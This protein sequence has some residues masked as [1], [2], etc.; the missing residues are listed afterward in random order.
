MHYGGHGHTG[1]IGQIFSI[2]ILLRISLYFV[3]H[4]WNQKKLVDAKSV[5]LL[6]TKL[7]EHCS[8]S[9]PWIMAKWIIPA[10]NYYVIQFTS[11]KTGSHLF[12]TLWGSCI[13]IDSTFQ[14]NKTGVGLFT[15]EPPKSE[16]MVVVHKLT[17]DVNLVCRFI[18]TEITKI[19]SILPYLIDK[20]WTSHENLK[21]FGTTVTEF[22]LS[23]WS[24]N[25]SI[26]KSDKT[27]PNHSKTL[28]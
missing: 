19:S 20:Y 24:N 23:H 2:V 11:E 1:S 4:S 12:Y 7:F 21:P 3:A 9:K 13:F 5:I 8:C 28:N 22:K 26:S 17:A 25:R 14:Y 6:L 16:S 15:L 10:S 18:T 27:Q